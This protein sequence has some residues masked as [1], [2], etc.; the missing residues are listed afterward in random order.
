M[1][2]RVISLPVSAIPGAR[3]YPE[4]TIVIGVHCEHLPHPY[5]TTFTPPAG[6]V[7]FAELFERFGLPAPVSGETPAT[8]PPRRS[9]R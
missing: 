3:T 9:S 7:A 2:L 5:F 8:L 4:G 6:S 1:S